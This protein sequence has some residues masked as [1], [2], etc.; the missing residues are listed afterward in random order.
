MS[1]DF[2]PLEPDGCAV[3]LHQERQPKSYT[4]CDIPADPELVAEGW[5]FRCNTD[6]SRLNDVVDTYKELG[7]E[8][9]LQP[10]NLAGL[11]SD[12]GGCASLLQTFS[13]VYTKK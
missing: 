11:S 12:C 9:H 10:V 1:E 6:H 7:F 8:I 5:Q 4:G 3:P 13:A 2:S